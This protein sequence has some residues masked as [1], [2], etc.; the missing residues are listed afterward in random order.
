MIDGPLRLRKPRKYSE[1]MVESPVR[2]R[3]EKICRVAIEAPDEVVVVR[4]PSVGR[5][6]GR[7]G[8]GVGG[9]I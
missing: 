7:W 6:N 4:L 8:G 3:A 2:S 5:M 1:E 9:E